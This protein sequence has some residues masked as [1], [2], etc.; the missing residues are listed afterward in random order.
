[1]LLEDNIFII[2]DIQYKYVSLFGYN[3]SFCYKIKNL[4]NFESLEE[5]MEMFSNINTKKPIHLLIHTEN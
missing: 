2:S 1:M 4:V 5:V 3:I